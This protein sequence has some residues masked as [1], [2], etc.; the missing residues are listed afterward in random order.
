MCCRIIRKMIKRICFCSVIRTM[1]SGGILP[2]RIW[3]WCVFLRFIFGLLISFLNEAGTC[4][5][6]RVFHHRSERTPSWGQR[7]SFQPL[8]LFP[9]FGTFTLVARKK[10]NSPFNV[11]D[12][13]Y[14]ASLSLALFSLHQF[15]SFIS[16]HVW[17]DRRAR[18]V[19]L[20]YQFMR[21]TTI[22]VFV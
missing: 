4:F 14:C 13:V 16:S 19:E 17:V 3:K 7:G 2:T 18:T 5:C 12:G 22:C 6:R 10:V 11:S 20:A 8:S 21:K 9:A 15:I 1:L